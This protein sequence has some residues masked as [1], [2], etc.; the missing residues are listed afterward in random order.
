MEKQITIKNDMGV[1]KTFDI[2]F[3]FTSNKTNQECIVYTDY[4]KDYKG[5]ISCY[6]VTKKG[7]QL[8]PI[9]DDDEILYIK[10]TLETLTTNQ[11]E[12]YTMIKE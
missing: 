6:C 1:E 2:V 10:E 4:A 11:L 9:E 3:T 5:N 8:L 12:K 7:N